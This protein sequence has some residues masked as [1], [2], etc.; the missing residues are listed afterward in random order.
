MAGVVDSQANTV[1]LGGGGPGHA[2]PQTLLLKYANRHG[3]IAGATGTGKTV[4]LQTLAE[5]LSLAGVPVFLADV[6]GDLA[7]L[8]RA[9][10]ANGKLHQ[11]FGER[12]AQI[13]LATKV[14]DTPLDDALAMA[15]EIAGK[16]PT[17]VRGAKRLLNSSPGRDV[18]EQFR[19]ERETIGSLIGS[20][21]QVEA[22]MAFFEKR[23]PVFPEA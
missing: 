11:A 2:V 8:S 3:L 19:D 13:G 5:S 1:F 18:A 21:N 17:A 23:D 20:P 16:S 7:G 15:H 6:K 14:S 10:D 12:A 9:G 4:T 22:V